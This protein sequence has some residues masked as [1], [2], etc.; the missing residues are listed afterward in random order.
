MSLPE[1]PVLVPPSHMTE[2]RLHCFSH[3]RHLR[4]YEPNS[5][6]GDLWLYGK[7]KTMS[8]KW[9]QYL[10]WNLVT[11]VKTLSCG[12]IED[13]PT[14]QQL[15]LWHLHR[16]VVKVPV[17]KIYLYKYRAR[18]RFP[19]K[20]RTGQQAKTTHH[21]NDLHCSLSLRALL[22][23][24]SPKCPTLSGSSLSQRP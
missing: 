6:Q 13:L 1:H 5:S 22:S 2:Q 21:W 7:R 14:A 20:V 3:V 23:E 8:K 18:Q 12:S 9:F 4:K 15:M 19:S 10:A 24:T 11:L 17:Q 16:N